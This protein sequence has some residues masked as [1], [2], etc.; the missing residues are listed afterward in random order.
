MARIVNIKGGRKDFLFLIEDP[1]SLPLH[2]LVQPE[3]C[4]KREV[5]SGLTTFIV[6]KDVLPLF[7]NTAE[8][9]QH[10]LIQDLSSIRP[11]NPKL[12]NKLYAL[13]NIGLQE[14]WMGMFTNTRSIQQLAF[15][16]WSDELEVIEAIKGM[17]EQFSRYLKNCKP[18]K[19]VQEIEKVPCITYTHNF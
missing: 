9:A 3:N 11:C 19:R 17:E 2:L 18:D 6:N 16:S 4:I 8:E 5:R 13:S 15:K 12:L 14:R 10:H 1:Q 7:I